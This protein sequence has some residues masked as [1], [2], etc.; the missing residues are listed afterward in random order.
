MVRP[1]KAAMAVRQ[2]LVISYESDSWARAIPH[3]GQ[4]RD[5]QTLHSLVGSLA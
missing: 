4:G 2:P 3:L 5:L 1:S